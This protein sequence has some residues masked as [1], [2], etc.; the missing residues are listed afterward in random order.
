MENTTGTQSAL[1][2]LVWVHLLKEFIGWNPEVKGALIAQGCSPNV[3]MYVAIK[4]GDK[5]L[6]EAALAEGAN[7]HWSV[8]G[9]EIAFETLRGRS[10]DEVGILETIIDHTRA[11]K[12]EALCKLL[13][14]KMHWGRYTNL[15][16]AKMILDKC[17]V[18][19]SVDEAGRTALSHASLDD[20]AL[21]GVHF[22]LKAG[23][24]P[25]IQ[26][27]EGRTA[28]YHAAKNGANRVVETLLGA[29]ASPWIADH[30]GLTPINIAKFKNTKGLLA[31]VMKNSK[32]PEPRPPAEEAPA[33]APATV[34]ATSELII[35]GEPDDA[36]S[37]GPH[38]DCPTHYGKFQTGEDAPCGACDLQWDCRRVSEARLGR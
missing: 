10:K 29:G 23:A 6:L 2:W 35:L 8:N 15:E 18:T 33:E 30:Y 9:K 4:Q 11:D 5:E 20:Y 38:P 37:H 21:G 26:D 1:F 14:H 22:L 19:N 12:R 32:K 16:A 17:N 25:D 34:P 13:L 24:D 28:L 3:A 31:R 7:L 36:D 27:S